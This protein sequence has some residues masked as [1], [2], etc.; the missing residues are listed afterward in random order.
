VGQLSTGILTAGESAQPGVSRQAT[1]VF[2][3]GL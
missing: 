3:R 1:G 2:A